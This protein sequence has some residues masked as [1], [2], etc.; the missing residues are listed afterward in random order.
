M[1]ATDCVWVSVRIHMCVCV[2]ACVRVYVCVLTNHEAEHRPLFH[3]YALYCLK[4]WV[5]AFEEGGGGGTKH[6]HN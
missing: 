5:Y 4:I 3:G 1:S 2:C 6:I